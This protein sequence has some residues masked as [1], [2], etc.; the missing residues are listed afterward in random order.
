MDKGEDR[1]NYI[2]DN[3]VDYSYEPLGSNDD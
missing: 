3:G 2:E 1:D